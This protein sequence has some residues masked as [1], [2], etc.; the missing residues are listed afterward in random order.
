MVNLKEKT[1]REILQ[2]VEKVPEETCG[3]ILGTMN[4]NIKRISTCIPVKNVS[5]ENKKSTYKISP[6]DYLQAENTA[7][8]NKMLLLGIYHSHLNWP[9]IPSETDRLAAFPNLSYII[10]SLKEL[11]F[12]DI[13]SWELTESLEFLEEKLVIN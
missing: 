5:K 10:I 9:A 11:Y 13:K 4:K 3:F 6:K 7:L 8:E 12:A 1:F 2:V